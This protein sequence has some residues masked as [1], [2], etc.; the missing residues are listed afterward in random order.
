MGNNNNLLVRESTSIL[1]ETKDKM[2]ND[3]KTVNIACDGIEWSKISVGVKGF[4]P[5]MN[6]ESRILNVWYE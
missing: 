2:V 3:V 5:Q 4:S 1:K 6:S